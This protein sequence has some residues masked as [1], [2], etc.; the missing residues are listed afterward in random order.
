MKDR[1]WKSNIKSIGTFEDCT[2][3]IGWENNSRNG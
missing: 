1:K 2:R 3:D